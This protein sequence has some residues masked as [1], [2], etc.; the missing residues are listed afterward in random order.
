MTLSEEFNFI[1]RG[2]EKAHGCLQIEQNKG[3]KLVGKCFTA[4]GEATSSLWEQHLN[5]SKGLGIIAINAKNTCNWGAVDI[6]VYDNL[7]LEEL[8]MKLPDQVILC[9][10]KSGGAH[11][12]M[13]VE[14]AAPAS[15][16]IKKLRMVAHALG[17]PNTEIFPKQEILSE[18]GI[19]NWINMPYFGGENTT[20]YAI[21]KGV[22]LTPEEFI[23]VAKESTLSLADLSS[24]TMDAIIEPNEE[25][26]FKDAPPCIERLVVEGFPA[27]SRNN[28]LFSMGVYGR[29]KFV[30]G[31]EDKVAEYNQR[32]MGPGTYTEV[33][34]IIRS[35]SKKGYVYKCKDLP[36][37]GCCNKEECAKRLYGLQPN[38]IE[39]K[40]KRPNILDTVDDQVICYAPPA[41]SKDEPYWVFKI[42]GLE[43]DVSV[44]MARSQQIFA[45]E[46]LRQYHRVVLPVKDDKWVKSMNELLANAEIRELAP[47]AGPEGQLWIHV[48]EFC[49]NKAKARAKDELILGKPWHDDGR[50]FFRSGD[51]IRY[52][53]QQRFRTFKEKEIWSALKRGGAC[54]HHLNVKGVHI[55]CWSVSEFEYQSEEF[56]SVEI[57][58]EEMVF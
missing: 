54:H 49:T 34:A 39:E 40:S 6:D 14:P 57:P 9:R 50:V 13:F 1:F 43:I 4:K 53:D 58:E 32:F 26:E 24:F 19:G 48:K 29:K 23:T 5:G 46:Y 3:V 21:R 8:S 2:S 55:T 25:N 12:Y 28:A 10:S 27:G 38:T 30:S 18:A 42:D 52:L 47:D 7:D 11:I 45:R 15:L 31:W 35:L 33:A 16:V 37:S 20:R 17:H 41:G 22:T 36:L 56:D 44:D 51:L